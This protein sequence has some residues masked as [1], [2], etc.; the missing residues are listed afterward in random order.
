MRCLSEKQKKL[1][2]LNKNFNRLKTDLYNV[3]SCFDFLHVTS[4]FFEPNIKAME[5][6]ELKQNDKLKKL[7]E[8]NVKHDPK[9]IIH[10]YS[11]HKLT[12]DQELL[13][14]RGLNFALPP[15]KLRYEDYMLPVELLFRD[16]HILDKNEEELVF[17]KNELRHVAFSS[18]KMYNKK[19]NK[20][21][22]ISKEEHKTF[23]ELLD[24]RNIIIQK[25]DKGS[26][27]VIIDR[28]TYVT[29]M[30]R[31]LNDDTKFKKV[32]FEEKKRRTRLSCG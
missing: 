14:I 5:K 4:L 7:L 6:I 19:D 32:K 31:I 13:L 3:L 8:E 25:A 11:S 15:K 10:N 26:V 2:A 16:F 24:L 22:N 20:L 28:N 1:K 29:R 21:E 9:Q 17:A 18:F 30:H 27:I 12:P 23:L